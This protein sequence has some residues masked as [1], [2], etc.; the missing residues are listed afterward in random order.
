MWLQVII[1]FMTSRQY[2]I[3]CMNELVN[4]NLYTYKQRITVYVFPLRCELLVLR[5][6]FMY[7]NL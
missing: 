7:I 4:Y 5:S 6:S 1:E 3:V 2:L